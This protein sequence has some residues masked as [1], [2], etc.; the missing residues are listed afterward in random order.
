MWYGAVF[1]DVPDVPPD[2]APDDDDEDDEHPAKASP[3]ATPTAPTAMTQRLPCRLL[4]NT[5]P[6]V[7]FLGGRPWRPVG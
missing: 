6:L 3:A 4:I 5:E 7:F 2:V 1:A